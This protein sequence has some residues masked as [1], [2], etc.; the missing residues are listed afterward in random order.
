MNI[1][2]IVKGYYL[3]HFEVNV[4]KVFTA[5]KKRRERGKA[6][7][8]VNHGGQLAHLLSELVDPLWPLYRLVLII[9]TNR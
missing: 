4:G 9:N 6:F 7:K 5:N 1:R 2:C 3:C 8:V